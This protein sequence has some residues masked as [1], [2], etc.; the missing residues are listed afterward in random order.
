MHHKKLTNSKYFNSKYFLHCHFFNE[1][2]LKYNL[3]LNINLVGKIILYRIYSLDYY[4]LH[5]E[6]RNE[7]KKWHCSQNLD[8][9]PVYGDSLKLCADFRTEYL[10]R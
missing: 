2:P 10:G 5:L 3:Y 1:I 7:R 9:N 8:F 6:A 4:I